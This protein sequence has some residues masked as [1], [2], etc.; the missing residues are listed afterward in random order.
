MCET[1][2]GVEWRGER[3]VVVPPLLFRGVAF[4]TIFPKT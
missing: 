1:T 3:G 2:G 4:P